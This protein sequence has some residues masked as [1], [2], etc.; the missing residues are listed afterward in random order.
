[1][2]KAG[3]VCVSVTLLLYQKA[4]MFFPRFNAIWHDTIRRNVFQGSKQRPGQMTGLGYFDWLISSMTTHAI[5]IDDIRKAANRIAKQIHVTPVLTCETI[6]HCAGRSLFFKCENFQK[7]GAFKFR[8]ASNAVARLPQDVAQRG[9]VTHSSGNHAQALALA[10][11]MRG[12]PASLVIPRNAPA[13][14]RRAVEGYGGRVI[15][16][17]PTLEARESTAENVLAETKGTLIPPFNHPDIMA[18]QG[19]VALELLELLPDLDAIIAPVGGGGLLSGI[20]VAAKSINP[21]ISIVGA[22]PEGANDAARSKTS[23]KLQTNADPR[24]IADGLLTSLGSLTWPIIRDL[25]DDIITVSDDEIRT[26]MKIVWE[27]MKIIIEPSSAV[28]LAAVFREEFQNKEGLS[29]IGV[30][31]SGGNLDLD[32]WRW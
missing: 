29:R 19:T 20:A 11:K 7:V 32:L 31:L 6:N 2:L 3:F 12:I 14:K 18:G 21:Q 10:A 8:G 27:R 28:A 5:S 24:T 9:V 17:E 25:V 4:P 26:S 23:G 1:M 15:S 13:V 22:E 16:C 30:I